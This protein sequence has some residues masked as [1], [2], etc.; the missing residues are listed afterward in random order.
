[1]EHELGMEDNWITEVEGVEDK[2]GAGGKVLDSI[3][4]HLIIIFCLSQITNCLNSDFRTSTLK[5]ATMEKR[6][7]NM[8]I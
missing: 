6:V 7:V 4:D 8:I 3:L 2:T 5:E 1:M